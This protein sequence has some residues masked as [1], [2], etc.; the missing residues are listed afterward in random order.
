MKALVIASGGGIGDALFATPVVR[1]LGARYDEVVALTSPAQREAIAGA[2]PETEVW[3]DDRP[4]GALA[5]RLAAARFDAAVVTWATLRTALLSYLA[6]IPVRVGQA[7]RLYSGLFTAPVIVR[8]ELG[9]RATHWTQILLDYAR[10][11]GC[12][13]AAAEVAPRFA[14]DERAR[15]SVRALLAAKGFG[16]RYLV[17]HPTRGIAANRSRWPSE[18]LGALA[19]A[20]G[21]AHGA[22]LAITGSAADRELAE[23]VA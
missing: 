23:A 11:L 6:R 16:E 14:V 22:Q 15:A 12:D 21:A 13:L 3:C 1:A 17:F 4:L 5:G 19:R 7:R 8:S 20:L 18:H 9:D 2:L 10:A